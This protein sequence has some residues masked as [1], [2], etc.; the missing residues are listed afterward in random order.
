MLTVPLLSPG[1]T[2][3]SPSE[4]VNM[5]SLR[6]SKAHGGRALEYKHAVPPGLKAEFQDVA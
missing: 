6:D 3:C 5:P 2:A 4:V 1:G